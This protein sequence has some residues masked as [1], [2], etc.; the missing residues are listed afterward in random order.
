M[1]KLYRDKIITEIVP[2]KN[3]FEA[4]NY[5]KNYYENYKSQPYCQLVID[6]KITKLYKLFP[7]KIKN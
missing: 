5:H 6:P 1:Q 2:Y 4:E 3:F 7:E